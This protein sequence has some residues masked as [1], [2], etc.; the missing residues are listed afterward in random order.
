MMGFRN[1][2][3]RIF[4]NLVFWLMISI[5]SIL[6]VNARFSNVKFYLIV[7]NLKFIIVYPIF[8]NC[9]PRSIIQNFLFELNEEER[10]ES[11]KSIFLCS[12]M[13]QM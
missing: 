11:S 8:V 1:S 6:K 2:A 3:G 4:E 9:T 10:G 12:I 5:Q 13:F 7:K